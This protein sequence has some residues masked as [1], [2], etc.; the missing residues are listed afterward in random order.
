MLPFEYPKVYPH[1]DIYMNKRMNVGQYEVKRVVL[2]EKIHLGLIIVSSLVLVLSVGFGMLTLYVNQKELPEGVIVSGWD[3]GGRPADEVLA[4]LDQRLAALAGTKVKLQAAMLK[5]K[6]ETFTLKEAGVRYDAESFREAVSKLQD[7][8]G[9]LWEQMWFRRNFRS[10]WEISAAWNRDLLKKR[11][12]EEWEKERFGE[13]VN[14]VRS[15]SE[16]DIVRYMPEKTAYRIDWA[17]LYDR[18]GAALPGDLSAAGKQAGT[19]L[20]LE[21]PLNLEKPP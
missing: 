12:N 5:G 20:V 15:I 13:P 21:L 2:H 10:E 8:S 16:D 14:A 6:T 18:L 11:L 9:T 7:N 17:M 3:V 4:E 19:E 1:R